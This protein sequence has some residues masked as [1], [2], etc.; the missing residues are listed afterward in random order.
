M[1]AIINFIHSTG[2]Y[3]FSQGETWKCLVMSG[4]ACVLL[5]LGIVRKFKPLLLVT[6][7]FGMLLTNLPGAGMFHEILFREGI[8]TGIC[9]E[10]RLLRRSSCL[11]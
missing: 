8:S 2:Y 11:N 6:I 1:G 5:Y 7:A 9:S 3:L 4:I 10:A